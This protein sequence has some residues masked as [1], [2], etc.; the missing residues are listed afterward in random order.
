MSLLGLSW[1]VSLS[2]LGAFWEPLGPSGAIR[3]VFEGSWTVLEALF[4]PLGLSWGPRGNLL[5]GLGPLW[6]LSWVPLEPS[7]APQ[8]LSWAHPGPCWGPHGALLRRFGVIL[9]ALRPSLGRRRRE[10]R[11]LPKCTFSLRIGT[12]CPCSGALGVLFEP[13]WSC[14]GASWAVWS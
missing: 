7:W 11:E 10:E 4:D 1:A 12:V 13:T 2:P 8:E 6:G 3:S 9:G 14:S 5:G